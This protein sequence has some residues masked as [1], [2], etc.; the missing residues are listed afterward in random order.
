MPQVT[1]PSFLPCPQCGAQ[2][3]PDAVALQNART[4]TFING[5][6]GYRCPTGHQFSYHVQTGRTER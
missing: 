6:A 2:G 1:I 5:R 4:G 3:Q